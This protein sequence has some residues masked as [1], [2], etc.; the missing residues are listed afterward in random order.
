VVAVGDDVN[1]F[2]EAA[3]INN[4][5]VCHGFSIHVGVAS[6]APCRTS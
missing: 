6:S 3:V 1:E 5:S 2:K 4:V